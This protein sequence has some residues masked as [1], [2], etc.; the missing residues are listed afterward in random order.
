VLEDLVARTVPGDL[1]AEVT[2]AA[3][4][5]LAEVLGGGG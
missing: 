1:R 4:G 2:D 3:V 5:L